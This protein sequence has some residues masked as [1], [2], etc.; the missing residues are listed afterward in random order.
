M[1]L[2]DAIT[3]PLTGKN[4][5]HLGPF[6]VMVSGKDDLGL[7]CGLMNLGEDKAR[8]LLMS[9][10]YIGNGSSKRFAIAGP[11]IGSPYAVILLE[12]LISWGARQFIF[13][14][15]CGAVSH[16]V[17]IGDVIVPTSAV[18]DE[19]T[20]KHYRDRSAHSIELNNVQQANRGDLVECVDQPPG[21]FWVSCPSKYI[22]KK[23]TGALGTKGIGFREGPVWTTDAIYRE[24]RKKVE[25]FQKNHVLAV[26]MET[27]ALLTVGEFRHVEVGA[28]L[29]VSDELSTFK[30][31]PGFREKRFIKSR[32]AVIEV[33]SSLCKNM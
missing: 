14:G 9:K 19:G 5:P 7:L 2:D 31:R 17:K 6:A 29:V 27:S 3:Y 24:T 10:I 22:V 26:E 18:I 8:D 13:F 11:L 16:D 33:I 12:H 28:I 20:S 23:T 25:Y 1:K 30:W 4:S 15:W 32:K 21:G